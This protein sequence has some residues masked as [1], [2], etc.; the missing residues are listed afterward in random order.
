MQM[1]M[2]STL[3]TMMMYMFTIRTFS[4]ADV[5]DIDVDSA[6]FFWEGGD[7]DIYIIVKNEAVKGEV[8]RVK[9]DKI[10][11]D[12]K[13]YSKGSYAI[14]TLDKGDNYEKWAG[15]ANVEDF[16]DEE[17]MLI[18]DLRGRVLLVTGS[19]KATSGNLYGIVTY[20]KDGRYADLTI[21]TAEGEEVDYTAESS[22]EFQ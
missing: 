17:V 6:I 11:V 2:I 12:G 7:D 5:E 3:T 15:L 19:A 21:F 4:K 9:A 8:E 22:T 18:L 1:K 14:L 13:E 16:V 10:K 20:A